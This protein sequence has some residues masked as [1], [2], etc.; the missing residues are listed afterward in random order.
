[1]IESA[2]S[3]FWSQSGSFRL[4]LHPCP[5]RDERRQ[6]R[7]P[8]A[9]VFGVRR[10]RP[11]HDA[12]DA[13][14]RIERRRAGIAGAGAQPS[15]RSRVSGSTRR[16]CNEPGWPVTASLASRGMPS[17]YLV[18]DDNYGWNLQKIEIHS[19]KMLK[20]PFINELR[21]FLNDFLDWQIVVA[22]DIP[23]KEHWPLMGIT[24]R[25]H[26]IIGGLRR[27]VL[28]PEFKDFKIPGSRPGTGFD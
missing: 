18:V 2:D 8:A 15:L 21:T 20:V 22:V 7:Q 12:D 6:P 3:V 24:I 17:D 4:F 19:L 1:V 27:E 5:V 16:I 13:A 14:V 28:P 9:A 10:G 11:A 23:G 26:E 25:K